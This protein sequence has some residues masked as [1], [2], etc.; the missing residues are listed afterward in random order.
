M[1]AYIALF[2]KPVVE[3]PGEW[4]TNRPSTQFVPFPVAG[5][6]PTTPTTS[7]DQGLAMI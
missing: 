4:Q 6:V 3:K 5:K 1:S 2:P 7:V